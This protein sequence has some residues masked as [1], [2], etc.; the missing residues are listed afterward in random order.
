MM[1]V[2]GQTT[3]ASTVWEQSV[4]VNPGTTYFFE[5]WAMNLCCNLAGSFGDSALEFYI[6][7]VL[8]GSNLTS[9]SGIWTGL[10]NTWFSAGSS[11]ATLEIRNGSTIYSGNDFA[12]DDLYLGT[13]SNLNPAPEPASMLLL[14][15]GIPVARAAYRRRAA[16]NKSV[17]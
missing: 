13:E 8:L 1:L 6:N 16:K 7:G 4:A 17:S 11:L 10:S 14:L 2:N 5:A 3:S 15:T 12:L 9:G